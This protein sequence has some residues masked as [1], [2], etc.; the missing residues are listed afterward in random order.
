MFR[1]VEISRQMT[2]AISRRPRLS[3][4]AEQAKWEYALGEPA[5]RAITEGGLRGDS[6][7]TLF[8]WLGGDRDLARQVLQW[9]NTPMFNLTRPFGDLRE[10]VDI[11]ETSELA[12]LALMAELRR[13]YLDCRPSGEFDPRRLWRHS[14]AVGTVSAM[15]ARTC[16]V[17]DSGEAFLAGTMHDIGIGVTAALHPSDL[18]EIYHEVDQLSSFHEVEQDR[19]GWDHAALGQEVLAQ[20]MMPEVVQQAAGLH[21]VKMTDADDGRFSPTVCCVVIANYLCCRTGWGVAEK[22]CLQTPSDMVFKRLEIGSEMLMVIWH[23][24]HETLA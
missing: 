13:R 2:T 16:G 10:A 3:Q 24:L 21:H 1:G 18:T 19:N 12:R 11:L 8:R 17:S 6:K 9:C 22:P 23:Q 4:R 7:E 15:I 5:R 20:W 14:I